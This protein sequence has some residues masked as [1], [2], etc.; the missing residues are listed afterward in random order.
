MPLHCRLARSLL[1]LF[2][3]LLPMLMIMFAHAGG[4]ESPPPRAI[5]Q[6][7]WVLRQDTLACRPRGCV[8]RAGGYSVTPTPAPW[9]VHCALDACTARCCAVLYGRARMLYD[10]C[11]ARSRSSPWLLLPLQ[12][13]ALDVV[14]LDE[15][16]GLGTNGDRRRDLLWPIAL[17]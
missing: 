6:Y 4:G 8:A 12:R 2:S 15:L 1:G 16:P 13:G 14:Q 10:V 11:R 7:A 17:A 5:M 9:S 3:S